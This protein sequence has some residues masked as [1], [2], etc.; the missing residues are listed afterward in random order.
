[1]TPWFARASSMPQRIRRVRKWTSWHRLAF[2]FLLEFGKVGNTVAWEYFPVSLADLGALN[3]VV[4][5]SWDAFLLFYVLLHEVLFVIFAHPRVQA[6]HRKLLVDIMLKVCDLV[7][8]NA[9]S[10]V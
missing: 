6:R 7:A 9:R 8:F 3:L 10:K 5:G 1:M 4:P 2:S